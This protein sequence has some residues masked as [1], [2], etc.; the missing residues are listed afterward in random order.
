MRRSLKY[1]LY[2]AVL[3]G[4]VGGT[5]AF[6]TGSNAIPV[7]LVV[8]GHHQT[9]HTTASD[10]GGVLA[11]QG[12]HV[13]AHDILAP[14]ADSTI[15]DGSTIVFQ[16]GRLLHLTVDGQPRDVWT[17][18]PTVAQAMNDLGYSPADYVSVSRSSRLPLSATSLVLRSPKQ[19]VLAADRHHRELTTT[20]ATVG[21]VLSNAGIRLD[22]NDR[23]IPQAAHKIEDGMRIT[24]QRI[25]VKKVTRHQAIAYPVHKKNDASMYSGQTTVLRYGHQGTAKVTYELTY[26]YGKRVKTKQLERVVLS[27][28]T[29]Q[30]E[31][32]GTK[33]RP[34]VAVRSSSNGLDWDAVAECESGGNWHINTGNG[35]YGG[36]QF[37]SGT[38]LSN[39]GGAYAP[40]AD[41]ASRAQQI[42]VADKIYASRGSSPWPV[43]GQYL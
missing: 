36:L 35:Y 38:W 25:S 43:C 7:H 8:D 14:A 22:G 21:Q 12:Y 19:I 27:A 17:T 18:A 2:G 24:V 28:P 10:V 15:H 32:V 30:V 33:A 26:V 42:A 5:A 16:R 39:G 41:L 3:A 31:R 9:I 29:P 11:A 4:L 23:V 34:A 6:T 20:G 13:D 37:D 1:G 40:R